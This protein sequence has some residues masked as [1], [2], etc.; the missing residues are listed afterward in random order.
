MTRS[1]APVA[2]VACS[3]SAS[4]RTGARLGGSGRICL[5][6]RGLELVDD[7]DQRWRRPWIRACALYAAAGMPDI[8]DDVIA[9]VESPSVSP[10]AEAAIVHETLAALRLRQLEPR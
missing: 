4:E 10:D 3:R 9:V 1:L 5:L 6:A 2:R 7:P 8:V